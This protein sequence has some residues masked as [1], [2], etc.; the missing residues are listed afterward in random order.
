[1]GSNSSAG[2]PVGFAPPPLSA[3]IRGGG[4]STSRRSVGGGAGALPVAAAALPLSDPV[5]FQLA[6]NRSLAAITAN[7]VASKPC[8]I[9]VGVRS[10]PLSDAERAANGEEEGA[11]TYEQ[12]RGVL[13]EA[14]AVTA[15]GLSRIGSVSGGL[16]GVNLGSGSSANLAAVGALIPLPL[17]A[18]AP[19]PLSAAALREHAFDFV[20]PPHCG[21]REVFVAIGAPIV[22]AALDGINSTLFACECV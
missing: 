16:S 8:N 10:R 20:F 9:I 7:K 11:W 5:T 17:P 1:M 13:Y 12:E 21:T 3:G 2:G 22:C 6:R 4:G 18:A 15:G 14:A 19:P